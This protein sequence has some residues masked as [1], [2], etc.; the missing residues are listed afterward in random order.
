MADAGGI[1]LWYRVD[2]PGSVYVP[3]RCDALQKQRGERLLFT[4]AS[5]C[6]LK[7]LAERD[8]AEM[9]PQTASHILHSLLS[10]SLLLP[11]HCEVFSPSAMPLSGSQG[12]FWTLN[13]VMLSVVYYSTVISS[14]SLWTVTWSFICHT[15][16]SG[17]DY[18][19]YSVKSCQQGGPP[20]FKLYLSL[21]PTFPLLVLQ[22]CPGTIWTAPGASG[23]GARGRR[24]SPGLL[25]DIV[26]PPRGRSQIQRAAA[27]RVRR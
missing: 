12:D 20:L 8:S 3:S 7:A 27:L 11:L 23:S 13:V 25:E 14:L 21:T 22:K 26:P 9:Q 6:T 16:R 5:V 10:L 15:T 19:Q 17:L 24:G 2:E 4:G 18:H 1:S